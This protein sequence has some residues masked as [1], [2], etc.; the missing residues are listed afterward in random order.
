MD[1]GHYPGVFTPE[2]RKTMSDVL[3][4]LIVIPMMVFAVKFWLGVI[5]WLNRNRQTL[6]QRVQRVR[7]AFVEGSR[8]EE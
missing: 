3:M 1:A 5:K 4:W 2:T 6:G 7:S 8:G